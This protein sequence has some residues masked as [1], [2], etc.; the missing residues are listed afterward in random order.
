[1]M[2]KIRLEL[3][4]KEREKEALEYKA[5]FK[6]NDSELHGDGGMEKAEDYNRWVQSRKDSHNE[7][8]FPEGFVP[9]STYFAVRESDNRIGIIC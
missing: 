7:I 4:S 1:M 8:S 9:A 3:P 6:E 2:E 5:E